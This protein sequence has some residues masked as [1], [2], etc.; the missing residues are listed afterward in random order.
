MWI[1]GRSLAL[2]SGAILV[3][4]V[5][6]AAR[7]LP[8]AASES[9]R[10][11]SATRAH[12]DSVLVELRARD[13]SVL[14]DEQRTRR[15][16]LV[17]TLRAYRE[18]GLFPHNYDFADPT[19]YFIDRKTGTL[20]AVGHLMASTGRRDIVDR[21][22]RADN[23]VWVAELAGDTAVAG[24]LEVNGLTLAEAARIQVPYA[25]EVTQA[26]VMSYTLGAP[27]A[28]T[29]SLVSSVWN[30]NG[31]ASGHRK[32]IIILGI[33]SGVVTSAVSGMLM[34]QDGVPR[35]LHAIGSTGM[36]IG[37][38]ST[39]LAIRS[40]HHRGQFMADRDAAKTEVRRADP[41]TEIVPLLNV[42]KNASAGVAMT[43]RF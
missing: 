20:C 10:I 39:A 34:S 23:N 42:G 43:V 41:A 17:N 36:A 40:L 3:L 16:Q 4:S 22:A 25:P 29:G 37:A 8:S 21:V 38:I 13:L 15:A 1:L 11:V 2:A 28:L 12:F 9:A 33:A 6:A 35:S 27:I 19:P 7:T 32:S 30:A 14:T 26:K 24:W 31:N 5:G 18:R